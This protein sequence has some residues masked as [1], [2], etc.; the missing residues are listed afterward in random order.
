M[1]KPRYL[2]KRTKFAIYTSTLAI[3]FGICLLI[4]SAGLIGF[5]I[6][7]NNFEVDESLL[8]MAKNLPVFYDINGNMMNY[9]TDSFLLPEEIP[10]NLKNAFIALEDKRFYSHEGY[11]LYR[12]AGAT[13]KNIKSGKAVEGASTIT[14]QLVKNTHLTFEKTMSR[15]LKEIALAT[16]LEQRYEKD[17]I[18]SMYLSVIYFGSGSY[19]V[20]SAAKK[21]FSKSVDQLSLAECATLAG[22]IKNP[23]KYSPLNNPENSIERRNQVLK[24]M[25]NEGFISSEQL[26]EAQAEKLKINEFIDSNISKFY[27]DMTI[28]EVCNKLKITK[29]Q[30]DNSGYS[31][32]TNYDP[33]IQ[34]ILA[35]NSNLTSNF[36]NNGTHNSTVIL[37][38]ET[39]AVLAYNSSLG[40]EVYRQSGST[41]KPIV[42]YAPALENDIINLATPIDDSKLEFGSWTPE[43]FSGKYV[44]ISNVREGIKH[45]SNT[46]AAKVGS[47]VGENKMY[48][49]G[50]MFGISLT[51]DD[52]NLTI[53]LGATS[54]GHSPLKIATAYSVFANNGEYQEP[55]FVKSIVKGDKK[56][57]SANSVRKQII[58][59]ETAF[60]INDCLVDTVKDGTAKSLS[61]LPFK[62]AS[63]TGTVGS[64]NN[65]NI[66]TDAWNVSYNTKFTVVVWHGGDEITETGGGQPTRHALNLWRELYNHTDHSQFENG[67]SVPQNIISL[68]VDTYSTKENKQLTL[69]T[70][71]TPLL[72]IKNEYFKA[73]NRIDFGNS[74]FE[75]ANIDFDISVRKTANKTNLY[76]ANEVVI[77]FETKDI[78]HY[79]II[80]K[81][82]LGE[83]VI[84]KIDGDGNTNTV[85]D[86]PIIFNSQ[87]EYIIYAYV[88]ENKNKNPIGTKSKTLLL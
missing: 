5:T 36:S 46:I 60:L 47:Y 30:L 78:Y 4:L 28:A 8:P 39:G 32:H 21:Y 73:S 70:D 13:V 35:E 61:T 58:S 69:G 38:N 25:Y 50:N 18:L 52:K 80:R 48:E 44:G 75:K 14:Q 57:Y 63:K 68:P 17:E 22:I 27:V 49:Y 88:K 85:I 31:I 65:N 26:Q 16:K 62:L 59:K 40:Y 9:K 6:W 51:D 77:S 72:Y 71:S 82:S 42:V 15:K 64:Q 37:D 86:N 56:I 29:Y 7:S 1:K 34:E 87:I 66:N 24:V 33:A 53:S 12:I 81:D 84:C 41:L 11:D 3:F 10:N 67:F 54:N 2:L 55:V 45:S 76:Y 79:E 23:T 20:Q 19:G 74:L 43:N 83:S